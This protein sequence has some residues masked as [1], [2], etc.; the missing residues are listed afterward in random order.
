MS[1]KTKFPDLFSEDLGKCPKIKATF[2]YKD[3]AACVFKPKLS[4]LFACPESNL[5]ELEWLENLGV[6]SPVDYSE[7]SATSVNVKKKNS[8]IRVCADY[9]MG[10]NDSL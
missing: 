9:S 8:K 1:L 10:L 6:I 3:N 4:G 7:R 5:K 2:Q